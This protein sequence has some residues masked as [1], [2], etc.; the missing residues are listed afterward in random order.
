V[1]LGAR[2][3]DPD[4]TSLVDP[5]LYPDGD[6]R[7]GAS[8][9]CRQQANTARYFAPATAGTAR[10]VPGVKMGVVLGVTGGSGPGDA[11]LVAAVAMGS[12]ARVTGL[13]ITLEASSLHTGSVAALDGADRRCICSSSQ[14]RSEAF[15]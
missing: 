4:R 7:V 6:C 11:T 3:P 13:S 9:T 8:F 5:D 14:R 12:I 10:R 2:L 1:C 15:T